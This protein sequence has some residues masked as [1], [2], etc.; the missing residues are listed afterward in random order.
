MV[1]KT[2]DEVPAIMNVTDVQDLLG[3]GKRQAYELANSE[4]FPS[5]RLGT[6]IKIPKDEFIEWMNKKIK[7][8]VA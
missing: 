4:G 6:L 1:Y 7:E 2:M 5:F 8:G 3:I